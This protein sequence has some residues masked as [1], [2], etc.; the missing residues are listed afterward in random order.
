[1]EL[2]NDKR[3]GGN[4]IF[5]EILQN[6][7]SC[8]VKKVARINRGE[9]K[10]WTT[11][12]DLETCYGANFDIDGPEIKFRIRTTHG[13]ALWSND[14]KPKM[15]TITIGKTVF[16][17][18]EMNDWVDIAKGSMLRNVVMQKD[19]IKSLIEAIGGQKRIDIIQKTF[20]SEYTNF[21]VMMTLKKIQD[22]DTNDTDSYQ[23]STGNYLLLLPYDKF[24]KFL[25]MN[26]D[27]G[28][29]TYFVVVDV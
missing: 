23:P 18:E 5:I 10:K 12:S 13:N 25:I 3:S 24:L 15:V 6:N 9:T 11:E 27:Q 16:K 8:Q 28:P 19:E 7:T 20:S 21:N 17:S 14:F 2:S 26:F 1:M 4:E 29:K 22:Y